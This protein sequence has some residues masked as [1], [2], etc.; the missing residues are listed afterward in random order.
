V[1]HL[2]RLEERVGHLAAV[3][4]VDRHRVAAQP[5]VRARV[6]RQDQDAVPAVQERSLHR[7]EVHAVVD[8]VHE[9]DVVDAVR[10]DG[11]QVVVLDPHLDRCPVALGERRVDPGGLADAELGVLPV[12]LDLRPRGRQQREE[13]DAPPPLRVALQEELERLE[14]AH[15]VLRQLQPVDTQDEALVAP[16][17][18]EPASERSDLRCAGRLAHRPRLDRDRVDLHSDLAP[19]RQDARPGEVCADAR[20]RARRRQEVVGPQL[21]VEAQDVGPE[22]PA[23]HPLA[24]LGGEDPQVRE[25]GHRRVREVRDQRRGAELAQEPRGEGELI[26]LD[27]EDRLVRK[28]VGLVG[29]GGGERP[30][31]LDVL[32]PRLVDVGAERGH[33]RRVPQVVVDEPKDPVGDLVVV[34]VVDVGRDVEISHPIR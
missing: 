14:P 29:Q 2:E 26:V 4:G 8:R 6:A 1:R 9:Q 23:Q 20:E 7:D 10:G 15:D 16:P 32:L 30:V 18:V 21:R 25:A 28:P 19:L 17:P 33:P 22:H 24:D 27:Q 3:E 5:E 12:L 13:L 34:A 31:H 11:A